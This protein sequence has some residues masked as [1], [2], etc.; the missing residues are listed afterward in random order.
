MAATEQTPIV[1]VRGLVN[2]LMRDLGP[3][4]DLPPS[5]PWAAQALAP[6]RAAAEVR[7]LDDFTP[8]WAG[9]K[10]GAFAGMDAATVTL[11]LAGRAATP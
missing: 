9:T 7:G 4:S 2:R 5:F 8:L 11:R 1:E 3:M 10:P 6:L